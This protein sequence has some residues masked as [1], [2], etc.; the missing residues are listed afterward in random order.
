MKYKTKNMHSHY[1]NVKISIKNEILILHFHGK[2]EEMNNMLDI[3]S[4][5]YE[6]VMHNREGHNFPIEFVPKNHFLYK[7]KSE[8]SCK[9]VIGIYNT[10]SLQHE[11]MHAKFYLDPYYKQK[12]ID[13]WNNLEETKR[14]YLIQFIK[15][16]G[17]S[18]DVIIDE[19]Q[20]YK[21]TESANF[22]G[23]RL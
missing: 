3:I 16:M 9:Y 18:D 10:K 4:N 19:Y 8:K 7:Y 12:I 2:K 17:Y 23:I 5:S 15:K 6:G 22:F 13:E 11:L 14:N 1:N 20:A 21:Y